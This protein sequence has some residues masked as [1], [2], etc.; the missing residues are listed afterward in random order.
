MLRKLVL[1]AVAGVLAGCAATRDGAEYASVSQ[2]LGPPKSGQTR[3]VVLR[4]KGFAGLLDAGWSVTLD[5]Q[6]MGELKTGTFVYADSPAGGHVLS[7]NVWGFPG[8]TKYRFAAAPGRTYFF[9]ANV[10]QRAKTLQ[11][12]QVFGGLAGLAVA[13]VA[14]S[15]DKNPG[16]LDFVPMDETAA[17]KAITE[18]R[19][20]KN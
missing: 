19:S 10:S 6:P 17:R 5:A 9:T 1:C 15:D 3:V 14:T 11:G 20:A 12:A 13:A 8:E 7:V 2:T 4:D 16:P 18:L